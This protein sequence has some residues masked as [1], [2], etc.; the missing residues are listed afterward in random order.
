MSPIGRSRFTTSVLM[1]NG[2][3]AT[4]W[5]TK[6]KTKLDTR[7]LSKYYEETSFQTKPG[8]PFPGVLINER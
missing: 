7:V 3:F 2:I 4:T 5:Y 6:G 8:P 1:L